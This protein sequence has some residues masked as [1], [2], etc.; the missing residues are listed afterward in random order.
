MKRNL[1]RCL[2][3]VFLLLLLSYL[4]LLAKS[5][6]TYAAAYEVT[7][8]ANDDE[9]GWIA[10]SITM[11]GIPTEFTTPH[12]FTGL[13]GV[14]SFTVP[15]MDSHNNPFGF[16]STRWKDTTINV[17]QA[18]T[19]VAYY[20]PVGMAPHD[21][22]IQAWEG[23]R[24]S[25]ES[26]PITM[27][28]VATDFTTPHTFVDLTGTHNFT[29][30]NADS[31]G[32]PFAEW[33]TGWESPTITVGAEGGVF[34]ARYFFPPYNAT[35]LGWDNVHGGLSEPLIKDG[36]SAG[37]IPK[38]FTDLAGRH[39]FTVPSTNSY[40]NLFTGWDSGETS[41]TI[42]IISSGTYTAYYAPRPTPTP[43]P[44]PPPT[45][46]PSPTQAP[47]PSPT[48]TYTL[49]T[50]TP[51]SQPTST[52]TP[53]KTPGPTMKPSSTPEPTEA[54]AFV[55]PAEA[56]F[57]FGIAAIVVVIFVVILVIR[58]KQKEENRIV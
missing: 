27:D 35:I 58:K 37:L 2:G 23:T 48:P 18:G 56:F 57:A 24:G 9:H 20:Y 15:S 26:V 54:T 41:T 46:T 30:P 45:P 50:P 4:L 6:V 43:S 52:P 29:V 47:T 32:V 5:S 7:I 51:S 16:W 55:L 33:N 28:N 12:T 14:N 34:T 44:T 25:L 49:P 1:Y 42:S 11:N 40:G 19:Y 8:E 22:T 38:T 53:T 31:Y 17:G 10:V 36:V 3:I 21:V 39:N 13:T